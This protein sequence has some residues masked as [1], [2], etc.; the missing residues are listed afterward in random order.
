MLYQL[1][2]TPSAK[3]PEDNEQRAGER[4]AHRRVRLNR[5][6]A[7]GVAGAADPGKGAGWV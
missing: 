3:S 6:R 5:R 1:S 7:A 4:Q 2:Y